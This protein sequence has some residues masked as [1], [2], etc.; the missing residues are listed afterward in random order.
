LGSTSL[1]AVHARAFEMDRP[2][3]KKPKVFR[4]PPPKSKKEA[5]IDVPWVFETLGTC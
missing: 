3:S 5:W 2:I 4:P 1:L